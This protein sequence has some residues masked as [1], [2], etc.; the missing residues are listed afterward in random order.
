MTKRRR[1]HEEALTDIDATVAWYDGQRSAWNSYASCAAPSPSYAR[2]LLS[3]RSIGPLRPTR[4]SDAGVSIGSHMRLSF[5]RAPRS[6][7]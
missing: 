4:T 2:P 6:T 3:V 1:A 7:W 5:S